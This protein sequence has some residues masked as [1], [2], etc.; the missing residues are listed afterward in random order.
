MMDCGRNHLCLV[1]NRG[2]G[3]C[4]TCKKGYEMR[5][6]VCSGKKPQLAG[7][8]GLSDCEGAESRFRALVVSIF[9]CSKHCKKFRFKIFSKFSEQNI[10]CFIKSTSGVLNVSEGSFFS[11]MRKTVHFFF[12]FLHTIEVV[13]NKYA[14]TSFQ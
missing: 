8:Q 10:A 4:D 2:R 9:S 5:Y 7:K 14:S 12:K 1:D 6:G 3:D 11:E 13:R